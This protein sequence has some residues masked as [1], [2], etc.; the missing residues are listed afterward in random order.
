M[1]ERST[2]FC[3]ITR[4]ADQRIRIH[5]GVYSDGPSARPCQE[6][7]VEGQ[8]LLPVQSSVVTIGFNIAQCMS[9]SGFYRKLNGKMKEKFSSEH[10]II[11][12]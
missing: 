5:S 12:M 9:E 1:A 4:Q 11:Y 10:K 7:N 2:L 6:Q 3:R 8:E